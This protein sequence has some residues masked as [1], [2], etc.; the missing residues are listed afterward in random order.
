MKQAVCIALFV[1][2]F[3]LLSFGQSTDPCQSGSIAKQSVFAN[4]TTATT[5]ALVPI[6]TG[7][8][9]GARLSVY[10]CGILFQL[11][12][13]TASTLFFEQGTGTACAS[14]PVALTAT[15]TNGT[16]ASEA[17]AYGGDG[18]TIFK[19]AVGNGLCAVST[20]GTGPSI[21]VT[22]TYIQQ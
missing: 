3:A 6:A 19:T 8:E 17:I 15:Y 10:V 22:V 12:S 13:S 7:P 21:P 4:I 11:N 18:M 16:V 14:S 9:T 2:L 1:V 20:V 5:T